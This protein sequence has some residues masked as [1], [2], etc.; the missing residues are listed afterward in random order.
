MI[1]ISLFIIFLLSPVAVHASDGM[2]VELVRV[3]DGDTI[4]VNIAGWP[5]IVGQ[6]IGVRVA[7]CD[8][9]EL[10]DRRPAIKEKAYLAKGALTTLLMTSDVIELRNVRRGKY[11]RLVAD[12][13]ADDLNIADVLVHSGLALP[14]DGDKRPAW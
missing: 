1:R 14:Y 9:P 8:T 11:F 6:A 12:V 3:V 13:Y 10:R 5:E 2:V 4:I 7:D